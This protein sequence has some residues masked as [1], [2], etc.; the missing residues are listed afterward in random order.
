MELKNFFL[1]SSGWV[2][3]AQIVSQLSYLHDPTNL[4]LV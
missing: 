4:G 3:V 1:P 2:F